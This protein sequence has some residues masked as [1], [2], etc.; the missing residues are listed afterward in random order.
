MLSIVTPVSVNFDTPKEVPG[1]YNLAEAAI[2]MGEVLTLFGITYDGRILGPVRV[3]PT[4]DS[5]TSVITLS[6]FE[7]TVSTD[8][9]LTPIGYTPPVP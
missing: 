1:L 6:S 5:Q 3:I 9:M 7:A 2:D 8:D 4:K